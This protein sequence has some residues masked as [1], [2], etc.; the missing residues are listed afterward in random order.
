MRVKIMT[1]IFK[2]ETK[3]QLDAI[4]P[5]T[6]MGNGTYVTCC[7][8]IEQNKPTYVIV[9]R[10]MK[11]CIVCCIPEDLIRLGFKKCW[12]CGKKLNY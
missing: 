12:Y 9:N 3:E 6:D 11:R 1:R 7:Y 5:F 2:I 8:S 10:R 4:K